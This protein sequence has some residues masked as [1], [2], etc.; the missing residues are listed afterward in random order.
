MK[1]TDEEV[2]IAR[3][4]ASEL[5]EHFDSVRIFVTKHDGPTDISQETSVGA[6]NFYAQYGQIRSWIDQ[7]DQADRNQVSEK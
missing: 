4:A 1:I 5:M 6:G 7:M 2:A 3:K